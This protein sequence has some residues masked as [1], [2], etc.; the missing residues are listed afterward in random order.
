MCCTRPWSGRQLSQAGASARFLEVQGCRRKDV[1]TWWSG[2][3]SG[4]GST[5][6]SAGGSASLAPASP[7]G[8]SALAAPPSAADEAGAPLDV[9]CSSAAA[10][11]P[12]LLAAAPAPGDAREAAEAAGAGGSRGS[13]SP[14]ATWSQ[15]ARGG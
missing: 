11:A 9:P 4:A 6:T 7:L 14:G 13:A 1:Q 12:A 5:V 3:G 15:R 8:A 2:A 10:L